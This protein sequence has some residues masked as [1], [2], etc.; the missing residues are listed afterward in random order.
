MRSHVFLP[1]IL[2]CCAFALPGC[3]EVQQ[4]SQTS[5]TVAPGQSA[6]AKTNAEPKRQEFQTRGV[7][8]E[9][10]PAEG[11]I[12]I[13]HEE[14]PNYMPAM[15]MP[16]DVKDTNLLSGISTN[17][18]VTFTLVVTPDDGW[19][20]NL[21]K[22]GAGTNAPPERPA[23]RIARDVEELAV[24]DKMTDYSF[25][26]AFGKVI[27][28][29]D[30]KGQAYAFTFI[31][32]RCPFPNFCPRMSMHFSKVYQIL[33]SQPNAPTNWHLFTI[34]FDPDY[35]TP[36]RL[37]E[38]SATYKVD[39]QKWDF[40]TGAMIDID[41]IADQF[42]LVFSFEKGT[43][44]HNLRTVVVDKNGI[45]RKILWGNEWKPEE[46]AADLAAGARGEPIIKAEAQ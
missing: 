35:D 5:S 40:L 20:E 38:Y 42:G 13:R 8:Q 19:I 1:L 39:P 15:T 44:N 11:R 7:V 41:A 25:T 16:F 14:I 10:K 17:D 22:I 12:V 31:F 2:A 23:V 46:A 9:L 3:R 28:F 36:E 33:T 6:E 18:Q 37:R 45:I 29:S 26:N 27:R 32:T 30:F 34:T 21:K 24:G 4:P 43:F